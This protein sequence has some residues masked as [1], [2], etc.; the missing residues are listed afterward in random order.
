MV[1]G[2]SSAPDRSDVVVG[3]AASAFGLGAGVGRFVLLPGRLLAGSFLVE[4]VLR[5]A[6]NDLASAGRD[7]E[8]RGRRR[9]E[10]TAAGILAA[11]ETVRTLDRA[12]AGPVPEVLGD[13][14]IERLA[15]TLLESP[16]FERILRDVA[17]SRVV[18]D[19]TEE[20][21]HSAELQRALEEVLAGPAL[22]NALDRQTRT[23][24]SEFAARVRQSAT[25]LDAGVERAA[26]GAFRRRPRTIAAPVTDERY[27][28]LVSRGSALLADAGITQLAVLVVGSLV[29]LFASLVGL[30]APGWVAATL[31][32]TGWVLF[33][34]GYFVLFWATV[35]QTPGMRMLGLRVT[36]DDGSPLRAARSFLRF[37]AALL[38]LAPLAAGFLPV[39][40]DRRRRA[41]Q[42]F[43]ARTVVV[44]DDASA[45]VSV[46]REPSAQ[47]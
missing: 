33:V 10:T 40:F 15:R 14:T 19:L 9:L 29:G 6:R 34:G 26:R 41:F 18:R 32:G 47:R 8:A 23:L 1:A 5:R 21:V 12:L 25:R 44:H 45:G 35:G 4:P 11:P 31:G 20:A 36:D 46:R 42:D 3:V 37:A 22:R 7:A 39:L 13:E 17:E 24:W 38:A 43:V 30:S 16:A 2:S 28:G 27:A